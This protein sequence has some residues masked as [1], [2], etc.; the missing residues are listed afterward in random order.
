VNGSPVWFGNT[1]D[2]RKFIL[3][4]LGDDFI[5]LFIFFDLIRTVK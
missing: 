5:M 4:G 3:E 2:P 1:G